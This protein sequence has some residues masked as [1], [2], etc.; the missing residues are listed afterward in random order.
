MIELNP[1]F[2]FGDPVWLKADADNDVCGIVVGYI[3]LPGLIL[4]YDVRWSDNEI[5]THY[6]FELANSPFRPD[7]AL[8]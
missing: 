8:N 5:H 7:P 6:D 4:Q 3:V 2:D 1:V